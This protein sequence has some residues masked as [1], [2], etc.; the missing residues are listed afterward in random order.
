MMLM[1]VVAP[2]A[3]GRGGG[4]GDAALLLLLHPV[5]R[6]G[7]LVDLADLVVDARVVEDALGGRGLARIDV[8]H[9]ADVAG[10]ARGGIREPRL[11]ECLSDAQPIVRAGCT[12][13][14]AG[15]SSRV[16]GERWKSARTGL[17]GWS[18]RA[19]TPVLRLNPIRLSR[20]PDR[21]ALCATLLL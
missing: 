19:R 7:A 2:E 6:R 10:A 15:P 3:G 11:S 12:K 16:C 17:G 8:R 9:D 14:P 5:H 13:P 20:R 1:L 18:E 4:D 21:P